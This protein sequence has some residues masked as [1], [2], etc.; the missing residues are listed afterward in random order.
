MKGYTYLP[1]PLTKANSTLVGESK[2]NN[3]FVAYGAM[4][5]LLQMAP[6]IIFKKEL[7]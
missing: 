2:S 5:A 7:G 3:P 6:E 1:R 4:V